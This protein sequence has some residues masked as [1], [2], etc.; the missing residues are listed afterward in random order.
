MH[1]RPLAVDDHSRTAALLVA[2]FRPFFDDYAR[3]LLGERIFQ[4]QH[5]Q[6][7]QDYRD[8]LPTLHSPGA[9]RHAA[10]SAL[11]DGTITGF[12][13]WNLRVEEAHGEIYLLAVST[14]HR[15]RGIGRSLCEHALAHLRAAHVDVVQIGTGGDPFHAP[16][17]ALYARLGYVQ[18]PVAVYLG[19]P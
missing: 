15:R 11:T 1:I 18:V 9:G 4:H 12:V 19:S 14:L 8:E 10:V 16:A 6:W 13:A 2:T 7:E 3:P 17:R 5:G